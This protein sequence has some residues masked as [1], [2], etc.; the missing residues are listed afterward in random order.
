M[1]LP[2]EFLTEA[3]REQLGTLEQTLTALGAV[4]EGGGTTEA[5]RMCAGSMRAMAESLES[6]ADR[7][8]RDG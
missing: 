6:V 8:E 4:L 1:E 5:L 7:V 2:E 3:E